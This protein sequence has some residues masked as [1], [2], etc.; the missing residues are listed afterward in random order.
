MADGSGVMSNADRAALSRITGLIHRYD[1]SEQRPACEATIREIQR[2][3]VQVLND[4][5]DGEATGAA[6]YPTPST[7][8]PFRSP[9]A[10]IPTILQPAPIP[11]VTLPNSPA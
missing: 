4:P 2:I 3:A 9:S 11:P 8:T 7:S 6:G 1:F 10:T 5:P